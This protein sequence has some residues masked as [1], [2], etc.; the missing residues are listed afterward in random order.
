MVCLVRLS[1]CV[2]VR[3]VAYLGIFQST[4]FPSPSLLKIFYYL[5]VRTDLNRT[6]FVYVYNM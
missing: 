1:V 3:P 2:C 5:N 4:A 6:Y